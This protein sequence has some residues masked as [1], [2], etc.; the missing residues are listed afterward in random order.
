MDGSATDIQYLQYTLSNLD[1]NVGKLADHVE[2]QNHRLDK[3]EHEALVEAGRNEVRQEW[4][5]AEAA[6]FRWIFVQGLAAAGVLS[7]I[8]FGV[9]DKVVK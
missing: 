8:V 7:G 6:R 4:H 2:K 9:A 3:L 5:R 1:K